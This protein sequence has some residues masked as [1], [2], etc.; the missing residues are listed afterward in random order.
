MVLDFL[1]VFLDLGV[2]FEAFVV[3]VVFLGAFVASSSFSVGCS[4]GTTSSGSSSSIS[5]QAS[6]SGTSPFGESGALI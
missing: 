2:V 4:T 3:V 5:S 6:N 1:V